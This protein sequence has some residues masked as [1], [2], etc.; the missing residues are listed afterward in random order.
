[1]VGKAIDVKYI[2]S[3]SKMHENPS[4]FGWVAQFDFFNQLKTVAYLSCEM[5]KISVFDS[6]HSKT[7]WT[8][9]QVFYFDSKAEMYYPDKWKVGH[10]MLLESWHQ[11]GY[12]AAC[13]ILR[14]DGRL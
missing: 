10:W 2:Y 9:S 13:L 1:M 12:D 11:A 6:S 14:N 8:V 7:E 5:N 4:F 3:L